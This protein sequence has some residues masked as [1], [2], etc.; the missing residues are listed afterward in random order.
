MKQT[1]FTALHRTLGA[2]M[3][4]FAGYEMPIEYAGITAEHLCVCRNAGV[5]DVSHMGEFSLKGNKALDLLQYLTSNDAS[6]LPAGKAQYTCLMNER[7]GIVDD[8]LI[9]C[10]VPRQDYFLVVNASNIDKDFAHFAHYAPRF[11]VSA[12]KD[13]VN[14]SEQIAQIAVQGPKAMEVLQ[15]IANEPVMDMP[16]YTFKEISMAGI[17]K[18]LLATTGYTGAGGAE[19]YV[20]NQ[21]AQTLWNAVMQAG[22]AFDIAPIGLGARDTLR[23]EMGYSL[24]GHELSDDTTPLEANLGWVTKFTKPFL[25]A[26]ILQQQK[27]QG[28]Q[29][30]LLAFKL[31]DRGVPRQGYEI[32]TADGTKIGTVTSGTMSPLSKEGIGMGYVATQYAAIGTHI[33][34]KVRE[35][36]LAAEVVKL[37]F[38]KI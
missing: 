12:G 10:V 31:L 36:L 5:F 15:T 4:E 34:I 11:G 8:F 37:P 25:G 29:R 28:V 24:Y 6:T 13:L 17:P 26:D 35:K 30:K 32:C 22:T 2:K 23:L 33:F 38:R 9:Y 18:V 21:Y 7:G 3:A 14:I 20:D 16:N 1:P 27:A 19:L